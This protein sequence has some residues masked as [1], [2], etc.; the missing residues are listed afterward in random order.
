MIFCSNGWLFVYKCNLTSIWINF[1]FSILYFLLCITIVIFY[2]LFLWNYIIL[3][4]IT[5]NSYSSSSWLICV[6]IPFNYVII[7]YA[8][9]AIQI[10]LIVIILIAV[11]NSSRL[12]NPVCR[13]WIISYSYKAAKLLFVLFLLFKAKILLVLIL[14]FVLLHFLYI[15]IYWRLLL[16]CTILWILWFIWVVLIEHYILFWFLL[17]NVCLLHVVGFQLS[18]FL[19]LVNLLSSFY[20]FLRCLWYLFCFLWLYKWITNIVHLIWL[21]I[22]LD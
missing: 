14:L 8:A 16:Y 6:V 3:R 11:S 10:L 4:L 13:V 15:E 18:V 9:I 22:E 19:P 20:S 2:N 12:L 7:I 17:R 21:F 1:N 5:D